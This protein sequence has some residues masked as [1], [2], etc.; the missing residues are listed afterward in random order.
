VFAPILILLAL[1]G[2]PDAVHLFHS[3]TV[4][5]E[6][7]GTVTERTKAVIIPV[8]GR[9]VQRFSSMSV[10][11]RSGMEELDILEAS[12]GHWRGGRGN[13]EASVSTGPHSILSRTNRLES[14]LRES[15]ITMPGVEVGDTVKIEIFRTIHE[16]PLSD[17]YSYSFSPVLEDSVVQSVF[18]VQN[19]A[20]VELCSVNTGNSIEFLNLSPA[21]SHPLAAFD[22]PF[23]SIATGSPVMLSADASEALDIPEHANCSELDEIVLQMDSNPNSLREWVALN[24][25]YTGADTGVWPGWSPRSPEETLQDGSGVCR[26][27]AILLTWLLRRAG[28][29]AYPALA[30][31]RG[32]SPSLVDARS[33]DHMI[34]VYLI[35]GNDSWV[36]LDPTPRNLPLEAGFSFGLRGCSYLPAVPGGTELQTI[37]S[38]GWNDTLQMN[39]TGTLN[40]EDNLISGVLRAESSG[41]P[42][43]LINTLYS[44]SDPSSLNEMFRRFFGAISCDSVAFDGAEVLVRGKWTV[45][46]NNEFLLLPGLRE[47]SLPG[48][49]IASML[50]PCPPDSFIIDAPATEILS[51]SLTVNDSLE[52]LPEPVSIFGY[53]CAMAL[54]EQTLEYT[55]TADIV[56]SNFNILETLTIRSGSSARTLRLP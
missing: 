24:I 41:A 14:S 39:L 28:Y 12:V 47:I 11:F 45:H 49:R 54:I 34:T 5:F 3:V 1:S 50:L 48:S 38:N 55:E 19:Y 42:L 37:Q 17:V 27:R 15:V 23:I 43:E 40:L 35:P 10:S 29:E 22:P 18:T 13:S 8:T 20:G 7:D 52:K 6:V 25:N 21:P 36:L 46:R 56:N 51:V 9:G 2:M 26:D 30:T 32:E 33:F 31:T 53:S 16:L 4:T 44:Q